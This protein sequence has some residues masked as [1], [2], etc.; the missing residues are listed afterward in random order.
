MQVTEVNLS[1]SHKDRIRAYVDITFDNCLVVRGLRIIQTSRGYLVAMPSSARRGGKRVDIAHP[2]TAASIAAQSADIP[3]HIFRK[4]I[5][6]WKNERS[7]KIRFQYAVQSPALSP[8][9]KAPVE[10][11]GGS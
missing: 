1:L 5:G 8:Q 6:K 2:I 10:R 4:P 3:D 9:V 7:P 11:Q